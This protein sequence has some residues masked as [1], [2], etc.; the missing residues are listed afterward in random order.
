MFFESQTLGHTDPMVELL[1]V[2]H[3]EEPQEPP[4]DA[5][6]Q[7]MVVFKTILWGIGGMQLRIDSNG[8]V[9]GKF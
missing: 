4:T 2:A 7:H 3:Y 8:S 9:V 6:E 5:K 1:E